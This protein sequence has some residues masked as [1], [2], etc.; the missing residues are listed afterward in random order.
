MGPKTMSILNADDKERSDVASSSN[1]RTVRKTGASRKTSDKS[2]KQS[3]R[4]Q[5]LTESKQSRSV[6]R[7][8]SQNPMEIEARKIQ[9]RSIMFGKREQSLLWVT[10]G[11]MALIR[12]MSKNGF[13]K[14]R[15]FPGSTISELQ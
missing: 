8:T 14:V 15:C 5:N 10:A 3:H 13:V 7:T 9:I 1:N 12:K 6:L 4:S 11:H 2:Q